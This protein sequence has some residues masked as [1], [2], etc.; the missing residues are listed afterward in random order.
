MGDLHGNYTALEEG[1]AAVSFDTAN[2]RLFSVGDLIDRGPDSAK[3][4]TLLDKPWFHAVMGNHEEML[5]AAYDNEA[6][7][8]IHKMNGG[9]WAYYPENREAVH[10]YIDLVRELPIYIEVEGG[11]SVMHA[12][13]P[14]TKQDLLAFSKHWYNTECID[15]SVTLWGRNWFYSYYGKDPNKVT[16][17][18]IPKSSLIQTCYVG[19][20]PVLKPFRLGFL[21]NLDTGSGKGGTLTLHQY[22]TPI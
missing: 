3:C 22:G 8:G 20:T 7:Q 9:L 14:Y 10:Q 16:H 17:Q 1:L 2:D 4:L 5:V 21:V 19:H 6:I 11:F 13:P 18:R 15:G 12:E